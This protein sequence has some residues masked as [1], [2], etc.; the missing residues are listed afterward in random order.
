MAAIRSGATENEKIPSKASFSS[1]RGPYFDAPAY[2]ASRS[3]G[4]PICRKPTQLPQAPQVTVPL[5]RNYE[6]VR[7]PAGTA[8]K[9]RRRHAEARSPKGG[10]ITR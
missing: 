4:T 1:L 7:R 2:R 8:A 3:T 6:V 5:G 10:A 9:S